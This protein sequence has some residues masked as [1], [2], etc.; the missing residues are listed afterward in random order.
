MTVMVDSSVWINHLR[1]NLTQAVRQ[2]RVLLQAQDR[3]VATADLI[4]LEVVRGARN[5]RHASEIEQALS[6]FDCARLGGFDEALR[7][8]ALHRKLR[9]SKLPATGI[10]VAK[11]VDLLIASWCIHER[12]T[13]LHDD[14]DFAAFE[15][16]G[17]VCL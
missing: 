2:F 9:T 11:S 5:D 14:A 13:L 1:G 16:H 6:Q 8:A 17:L 7:A 4:V 10:T 3:P 15:P 12:V